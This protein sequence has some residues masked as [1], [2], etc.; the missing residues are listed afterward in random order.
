MEIV[1]NIWSRRQVQPKYNRGNSFL[2][3]R[4]FKFR[5][6]RKLVPEPSLKLRLTDPGHGPRDYLALRL[7]S[8]LAFFCACQRAL[9]I[10]FCEFSNSP[11]PFFRFC[12]GSA[13]EAL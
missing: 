3:P 12:V 13:R 6:A 10:F 11:R 4:S 5:P 1:N 8:F 9:S 7:F 2:K